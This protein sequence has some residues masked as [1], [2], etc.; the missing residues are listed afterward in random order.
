MLGF[1]RPFD[2][3]RAGSLEFVEN[4]RSSRAGSPI[5]ALA[6]GPKLTKVM[7]VT[8]PRLDPLVSILDATNHPKLILKLMTPRFDPPFINF[9]PTFA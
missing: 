1:A 3:L 5:R 4:S 9:G 8:T 7:K 2:K 6:S